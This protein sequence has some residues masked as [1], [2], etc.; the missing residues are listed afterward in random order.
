MNREA[1]TVETADKFLGT[2]SHLITF[3]TVSSVSVPEADETVFDFHDTIVTA[4]REGIYVRFDYIVHSAIEIRIGAVEP[5]IPA[6]RLEGSLI[7]QPP[8]RC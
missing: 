2:Y 6:I 5:V 1:H 7:E 4:G 3:I 8:N